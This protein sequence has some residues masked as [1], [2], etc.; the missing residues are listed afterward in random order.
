ML[1]PF[2]IHFPRYSEECNWP[3]GGIGAHGLASV[4][5]RRGGSERCTGRWGCSSG[6]GKRSEPRLEMQVPVRVLGSDITGQ[7]FSQ[8]TTTTNVSARGLCVRGLT[9]ELKLGDTVGVV[10]KTRKTRYRVVWMGEPAGDL[11]G[12]AGLECLTTDCIWD[13]P[14][15]PPVSDTQVPRTSIAGERRA[16]PRFR[17]TVSIEMH[18]EGKQPRVMGSVSDLSQGGCFV[19]MPIPLAQG[20]RLKAVLWLRETKVTAEAVVS[21]ARPGFGMGLRFASLDEQGQK[22]LEDFLRSQPGVPFQRGKA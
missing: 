21:G 5:V 2:A 13:F 9:R 8:N 11:Y 16:H 1:Q 15:P 7:P 19:V 4:Q 10:Y 18:P 22:H 20:T 12:Q 3:L 6:M 14:L 17:C